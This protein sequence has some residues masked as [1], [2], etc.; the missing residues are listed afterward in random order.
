MAAVLPTPETLPP[1]PQATASTAAS[2]TALKE[3]TEYAS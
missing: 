2:A 3:I 1:P